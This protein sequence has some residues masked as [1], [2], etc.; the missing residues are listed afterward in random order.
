MCPLLGGPPQKGEEEDDEDE[1]GFPLGS[2]L[3]PQGKGT[4]QK[5]NREREGETHVF[6]DRGAIAK[7]GSQD[8]GRTRVKTLLGHLHI[9]R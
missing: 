5:G 4:L 1:E 8:R 9:W 6:S 7:G 2:P 3:K